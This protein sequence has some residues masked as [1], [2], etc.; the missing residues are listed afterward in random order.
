MNPKQLFILLV[1]LITSCKVTEGNMSGRYIFK[2]Q[3]Y[4]KTLELNPD[5]SF[6]FIQ[7]KY[8]HWWDNSEKIDSIHFINKGKWRKDHKRLVL[9]SY[10]DTLV[11]TNRTISITTKPTAFKKANFV[12]KDI[13]NNVI[14]FSDVFTHPYLKAKN[15]RR[16]ISRL[17]AVD[18]PFKNTDVE[19]SKNDTLI[20]DLH[21]NK[22]WR[23]IKKDTLHVNYVIVI[24]PYYKND[25]FIDKYIII[26]KN[27]IIDDSVRFKRA[28]K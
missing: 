24:A 22:E 7:F 28:K 8:Y 6:T 11:D 21:Y 14:P 25:I 23:F 9:N 2:N 4:F 26:K 3:L 27:R 1:F 13:Y 20:F 10:R 12:F 15:E 18:A 5:H 19:I 16:K 17:S